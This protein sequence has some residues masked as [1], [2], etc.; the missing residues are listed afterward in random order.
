ME[1]IYGLGEK[2]HKILWNLAYFS[3]YLDF[4]EAGGG[5]A[6]VLRHIEALGSVD[7]GIDQPLLELSEGRAEA[8]VQ[9]LLLTLAPPGGLEAETRT[10][11]HSMLRTAMG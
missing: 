2:S 10:Q 5:L 11:T 4:L 6:E 1:V 3:S 7:L 8:L 9:L